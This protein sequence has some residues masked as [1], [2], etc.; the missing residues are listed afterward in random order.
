MSLLMVTVAVVIT[1]VLFTRQYDFQPV[2]HA[3][4]I[5]IVLFF[6]VT[7]IGMLWLR[8]QEKKSDRDKTNQEQA[9][10]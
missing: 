10:F 9:L 3:V 8:Q 2:L 5:A 1:L 6:G 4:A 7:L